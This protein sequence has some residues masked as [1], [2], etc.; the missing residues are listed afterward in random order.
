VK[1][2]CKMKGPKKVTCTV[3]QSKA[4]ASSLLSW[5]IHRGK[6]TVSHGRT[7]AARLQKVLNHL[8]PGRYR[9]HVQGGDVVIRIGK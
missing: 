1:V 9:L 2:T 5:S 7:S 8:R 3:K 6:H 4:S